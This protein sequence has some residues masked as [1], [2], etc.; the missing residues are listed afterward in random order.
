MITT[1]S[2]A[3]AL[4]AALN[5]AHAGDTIQLAAGNYAGVTATNL[6]FAS[7][8]TITSADLGHEAVIT[9]LNVTGAS[10]LTFSH[11]ELDASTATADNPF[12]ISGSQN[13]SLDHLNVHG[14]LDGNAQDDVAGFLIRTSSGVSVT[15]SEFQQLKDGV[16]QLDNDHLT[17]S[18]NRFH[19]LRIDGVRGG[20]SS[21]VTVSGNT[22]RDFY[23]LTGDHGDAI[24]FWTTNT[25]ASA[26][27][28]TV[29]DNLLDR[30]LGGLAQGV[31]IRDEVGNLPY[32]HVKI[33]GNFIIGGMYNGITVGGGQ[34]V[35]ITGNTVIGF[36]DMKSWI[37]LD[38][39]DGA[40]VSNNVANT[41]L[42]DATDTHLTMTNDATAPQA[43]DAG[44]AALAQWALLHQVATT[45]IVGTS[46]ADTLNGGS[47]DDTLNG[48]GGADL[49]TGGAGSDTYIT[50]GKATIVEA[51]GGGTDTV[52]SSG[53][54]SLAPNIENLVL[55]GTSGIYGTGN[56]LANRITGNNAANHLNGGGGGDTISGG[57]G[58]DVMTGASGADVFVFG[59]GEG[60]DTITDFG[61]NGDHDVLDLSALYGQGL[62]ATLTESSAGVTLSFATGDSILLQGQHIANLHATATGFAI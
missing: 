54:Y 14:S 15:N 34:D 56:A 57:G 28:I 30:G 2:S 8:V 9:G 52:Q 26:H 46:G 38:R 55:T 31:F 40:T 35:T 50:D 37:R 29:T 58:G 12:K 20:G 25:T 51:V 21:F 22:F 48:G 6:Q 3:A 17:I 19:D 49:L 5:S 47:G 27:D 60:H 53:S 59:K 43:S 39:V 11:L 36:T 16:E 62:T 13:I 41:Y 44:A 42:T 4:N 45:Q 10:G 33:A 23:P 7:G 18:N 24:Q 1:V 61:A 32:L